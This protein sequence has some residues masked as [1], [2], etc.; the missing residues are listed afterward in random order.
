LIS[1]TKDAIFSEFLTNLSSKDLQS[2]VFIE[3]DFLTLFNLDKSQIDN[4]DDM[5]IKVTNSIKVES[6]DLNAKQKALGFLNELPYS[7]SMEGSNPKAISN[8]L[9]KL[10]S[11]AN[12]KTTREF[13]NLNNLKIANR[14]KAINSQRELILNQAEKLR[15]SE[16]ERIK[17]KDGQ[18]I[19]EINDQI[20]RARYKAKQ[21]RL[22]QIVVLT[23][24]ANL[25]KSLGII[26]NNFKSVRDLENL[27]DLSVAIDEI[28]ELPHWYLYGE[29]A[30][31]QRAQLLENRMNDD[32]FIPELITLNNELNTV[33]NNNLLQTLQTRQ[34]DSPFIPE[35]IDLDIEK[36]KLES[37]LTSLNGVNSMKLSQISHPPQH[38]IKP[39][40]RM[41]VLLAFFV[42]LLISMGLAI[43]IGIV[44]SEKTSA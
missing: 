44:K 16:I 20:D 34:D 39:N 8:Y 9:N 1:R 43:I 37:S 14:L 2:Q 27:S 32:P 17:E 5:V 3:G 40:K 35:I 11:E 15:F 10:V 25:A 21:N 19:D 42:S 13:I 38:P 12:I 29:K 24:A 18:K 33:Q 26:E 4:L 41:I 31:I 30:L 6:P 22:N 7:V 28:Q 23:D 36:I